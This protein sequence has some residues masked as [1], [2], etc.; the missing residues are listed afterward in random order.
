[1]YSERGRQRQLS[2]RGKPATLAFRRRARGFARPGGCPRDFGCGRAD[3][4]D[5]M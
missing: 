4:D 1:M 2:A 3:I 5:I